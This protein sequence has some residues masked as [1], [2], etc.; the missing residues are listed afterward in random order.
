MSALNAI[1]FTPANKKFLILLARSINSTNALVTNLKLHHQMLLTKK[2]LQGV[3]FYAQG[4]DRM[5]QRARDGSAAH[6]RGWPV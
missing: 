4:L 3:F 5:P 1:L 6:A 2:T